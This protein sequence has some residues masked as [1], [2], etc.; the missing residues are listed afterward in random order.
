MVERDL[1]VIYYIITMSRQYTTP[2]GTAANIITLYNNNLS[3][4]ISY[5]IIMCI[6]IFM[7][8]KI[9]NI[10]LTVNIYHIYI[11]K[12]YTYTCTRIIIIY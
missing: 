7:F 4:I 11:Y 6:Y 5:F 8:I 9:A 2:T 1:V 10:F 3:V 12:Y